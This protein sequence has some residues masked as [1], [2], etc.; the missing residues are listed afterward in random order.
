MRF[1]GRR[2][3]RTSISLVASI[4]LPLRTTSS[5]ARFFC[6]NPRGRPP[7]NGLIRSGKAY[8]P[9]RRGDTSVAAG[10]SL[11]AL[12]AL[13][14]AKERTDTDRRRLHQRPGLREPDAP[15]FQEPQFYVEVLR[16][17]PIFA[18]FETLTGIA[19]T[20]QLAGAPSLGRVSLPTST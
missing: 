1:R 11:Q 5:E 20:R 3:S 10:R 18:L 9:L 7:I 4:M 8:G 17:K 19:T 2:A 13:V 14:G 16:F 12:A 15:G 6:L